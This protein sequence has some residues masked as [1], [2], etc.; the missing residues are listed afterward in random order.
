MHVICM[1]VYVW[2]SSEFK[3]ITLEPHAGQRGQGPQHTLAVPC[4][5]SLAEAQKKGQRF[6]V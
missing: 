2:M 4:C 6:R 3:L 1:C 5:F